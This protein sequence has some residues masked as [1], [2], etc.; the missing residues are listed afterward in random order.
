[1]LFAGL[2]PG[3]LGGI[4][5]IDST[6]GV[7]RV[8]Q[9]PQT[10]RAILDVLTRFPPDRSIS[11]AAI[12]LVHSSPQMGVRSAF[13]FGRGYGALQ[14]A[15]AALRIPYEEVSP[16]KWQNAIGCRTGGDKNISKQKAQRLFPTIRVT[17]SLADAL[18]IAEYCRRQENRT[19]GRTHDEQPDEDRRRTRDDRRS[20]DDADLFAR[21]P[22]GSE[23]HL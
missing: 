22:A 15:L 11:R 21:S 6:G 13:T 8:T 4:A 19:K 16:V 14:M 10:D 9:M 23:R 2:D 3:V 1:M 20:R 17:H 7:V 5:I 18:L 12:E